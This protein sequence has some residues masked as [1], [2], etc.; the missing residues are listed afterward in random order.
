M[1][2]MFSNNYRNAMNFMPA[3]F[4]DFF[5][6]SFPEMRQVHTTSPAI[7]V[8]ESDKDYKLDLAVP[9][10]TKKDYHINI[11][12]DGNL[13]IS[14]EKEQK[15]EEKSDEKRRWLRREF[16]YQK[17]SQAFTLPDDVEREKIEAT[18]NDGVLTVV[19]PK[20]A[21]EALPS[22]RQIEIK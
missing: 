14:L 12:E 10:T 6:D 15:T 5:N 17:F 2:P 20:K 1:L 19:L 3:F 9:G 4:N 22:S 16:S 18:V 11:T 8:T 21:Q 7:N 13:M